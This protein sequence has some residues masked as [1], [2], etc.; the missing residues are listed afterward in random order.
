MKQVISQETVPT[1]FKHP[2]EVSL[3]S[4]STII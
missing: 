1:F 4:M 2:N 3:H